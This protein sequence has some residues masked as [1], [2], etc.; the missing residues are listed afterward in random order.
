MATVIEGEKQY[1]DAFFKLTLRPA[2]A[3]DVFPKLLELTPAQRQDLVEL[4]DSNHVIIRVFEVVNR[5]AGNRCIP[6]IQAWAVSV[7]STERQR[8]TNAL[9]HLQAVC[10]ALD[11]AGCPVA[12]MKTLD[13]LPDLGNDLDL[14]STGDRRTI[15][16]V[17]TQQ[18]AAK[19]EPRSWGDRLA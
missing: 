6:E 14:V 16:N 5:V 11:E 3:A 7:L 17:L 4:A 13:H 12:V 15:L 18:F 1:I 9:S 10:K 2:T 19:V 8:I